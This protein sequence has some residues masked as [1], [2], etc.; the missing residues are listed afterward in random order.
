MGQRSAE[1]HELSLQC[2]ALG[3]EIAQRAL[4]ILGAFGPGRVACGSELLG[5]PDPR[6]S[7]ALVSMA[8]R[9]AGPGPKEQR[10]GSVAVL[11]QHALH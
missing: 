9:L 1:V 10:C 3:L 8:T 7:V 5:V 11:L 4:D 2:E 6:E